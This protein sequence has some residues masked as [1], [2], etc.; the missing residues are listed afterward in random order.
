MS[1][2]DIVKMY[3]K[4]PQ[5]GAFLDILGNNSVHD[6]FLRGLMASATPVFFASLAK[7]CSSPFIFILDDADEAGYFYNDLRAALSSSQKEGKE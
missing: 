6:V 5:G 4:L 1:I 7:K 2:E 3:E